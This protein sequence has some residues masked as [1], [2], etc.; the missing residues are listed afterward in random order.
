[1]FI[2]LLLF[3]CFFATLIMF[4]LSRHSIYYCLLLVINSLIGSL[5]CYNLFGFSW[6][7]V[8]FCLVYIGGVYILFVFVS[9]Y[10]PKNKFVSYNN[11]NY[12]RLFRLLFVSLIL[13][14]FRVYSIL[15]IEFSE[16]ICTIK[17]RSFY[18]CMCLALVFGFVLLNVV[19]GVKINY[20]R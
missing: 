12:S 16:Y 2:T 9:V 13:V 18:F 8:L 11:F 10:R 1:M 17:E 15:N 6:Y 14:A 3:F 20:C 5:I 4:S 7:S 19:M